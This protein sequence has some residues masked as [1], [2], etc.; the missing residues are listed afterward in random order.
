MKDSSVLLSQKR[1]GRP[2]AS[3][4]SAPSEGSLND[5]SLN[6]EDTDTI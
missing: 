2:T 6:S 1:P 5:G 4:S 3:L